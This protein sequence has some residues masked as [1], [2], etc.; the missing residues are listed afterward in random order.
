MSQVYWVL[1]LKVNEGKEADVEPLM[2]E[3]VASTESGEPG[4]RSYDWSRSE[5]GSAVHI[6]EHYDD[7][8]ACMVHL[9]NFGAFMERFFGTFSP[10]GFTIYGAVDERIKGALAQMK[11]TYMEPLQGFHR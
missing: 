10:T 9:Q 3:M 1:E 11:P 8:D 4:T 7:A 6:F 5:D 2:A